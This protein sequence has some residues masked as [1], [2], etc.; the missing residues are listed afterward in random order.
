[1]KR[2]GMF[3]RNYLIKQEIASLARNA[4]VRAASTSVH[5]P[6]KHGV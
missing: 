5:V 3:A 2:R 6:H 1:M 4:T